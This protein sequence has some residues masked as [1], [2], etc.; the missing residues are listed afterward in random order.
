MLSSKDETLLI[1][2]D[3]LLILDLGLDVVN[4][5]RRLNI[6]RDGLAWK[7]QEKPTKRDAS[8]T[9]NKK[10][11]HDRDGRF[12]EST[13]HKEFMKHQV[14]KEWNSQQEGAR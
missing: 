7:L 14:S 5:I 2:G 10:T 8:Q 9:L 6:K 1:R 13:V 11:K 3:S 12:I 4:G